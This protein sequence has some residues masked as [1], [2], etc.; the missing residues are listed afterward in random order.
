MFGRLLLVLGFWSAAAAASAP[1]GPVPPAP[2]HRIVAVGD[3]HGDFAAWRDV[4]R[5]AGLV[6]A[7]G[8]WAGGQT[9]F[10]QTGDIPDRGPDSR[11]IVEDVMRL[12][13][14]A[15]RAGGRVIPLVGNHEAMNMTDDLRYVAP[16]EFSAFADKNSARVRERTF[17]ANRNV[18]E[19]AYRKRT[20]G[21]STDQVK[22]AWLAATPLGQIE[23]QSAWHPTGQIGRWVLSNPAV[24]LLDGTLFVHGG[25]SATYA[26]MS[27]PEI[28]RRVA[29]ALN[30]RDETPAAIINDDAGPLWYRGLVIPAKGA[31]LTVAQELDLVLAA[32]GAK[33][34]VV[35]HTPSL[36]GIQIVE[37][38]R[39]IRI[40]TGISAAFG[41]TPSYLEI[42]DG[43]AT[44]HIV[45]RSSPAA[46]AGAK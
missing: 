15:E 12:Q 7:D 39:L 22:K 17:S 26:K 38:G 16:G 40:D 10:V 21:M 24:A 37:G 23:H 30:A 41:G 1:P 9:V 44:A 27:I 28:N 43:E 11:R 45:P 35:G 6:D 34:I 33:R 29:L 36:S 19:A 46:A 20:P 5:A 42:L 3:L 31:T 13:K 4:A 2:I 14:E 8:K 32:Y 25:L 18:I